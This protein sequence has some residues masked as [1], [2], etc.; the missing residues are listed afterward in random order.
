MDTQTV[1]EPDDQQVELAV[2][3]LKL[4]ADNTR[5]RILWALLHGEHSVN[6]LAE[7]VGAQPSAV[8]QH[9]AK[10]R[11]ARIV[12][13]RRQGNRMFYGAENAHVR[14]LVEEA[15]FHADHVVGGLPDHEDLEPIPAPGHNRR[16]A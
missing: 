1:R 10:L 9:L 7:H 15:L 3:T 11:M 5:L 6:N 2:Q 13:V 4:L 8:S 16:R 12:K 14:Q